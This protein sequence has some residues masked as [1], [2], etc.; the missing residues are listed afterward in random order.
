MAFNPDQYEQL[1]F[2]FLGRHAERPDVP[3]LYESRDLT[4]HAL[5]VGM[6]GSGKT[7][8]CVTLLEEALIDRVPAIVI[9]PKGDIGNL[10]LTFPDLRA[11]DFAPWLDDP[12]EGEK[13]ATRWRDGLASWGQSPDRIQRLRDAGNVTIYTP[14]STAGRPVSILGSLTAPTAAVRDDSEALAQRVSGSVSSLLT[15]LGTSSPDPLQDPEHVFLSNLLHHHWSRGESLD[16]AGLIRGIQNPPFDRIGVMGV[17]DV[18]DAKKRAGLAM[19]ANNLLG[20][21]SFAPWLDGDP[22]DVGEFL[23][24][25]DKPRIA[26]FS[27]AHLDEQQRMF[28]VSLLASRMLDW[29]RSQSGTS[30]LR[31]LFYMDEVMG[32]LP[33]VAN[34]PSKEP[35]LAMLKQ[36]RAAGLGLVLATQNPVDMDYKAL[37]NI[38]TWFLGRLQ[39]EQDVERVVEGLLGADDGLNRSEIERML[40]GLQSR[41][42]LMRNVHEDEP[43][44]IESR[45]ALSFLRGPLSAADI[46]KLT[47]QVKPSDPETRQ[48]EPVVDAVAP[49]VGPTERSG[50]HLPIRVPS[51]ADEELLWRP[52]AYAEGHADI[53]G[54]QIPFN[55]IRGLQGGI[56]FDWEGATAV[57]LD[58]NEFLDSS[59]AGTHLDVDLKAEDKATWTRWHK[60]AVSHV[61]ATVGR[62]ELACP[63]L[64]LKMNDG[65]SESAFRHRVDVAIREKRDAAVDKLRTRFERKV[66]RLEGQLAR[67]REALATQEDQ[68][69]DAG[70]NAAVN[71]GEVLLGM[72]GGRKRRVSSSRAT[73][74]VREKRDVA[75]AEE[76]VES[77]VADLYDLQSEMEAALIDEREKFATEDYPVTQ[78]RQRPRASDVHVGFC[79]LVWVPYWQQADG[80]R[81]RAV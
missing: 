52:M 69:R 42:F 13:I 20:A 61:T 29:C 21:P 65:E 2:F 48:T 41:R 59:K 8:L 74:V 14:G 80:S 45:W 67:A 15:L 77:L 49:V 32:F 56:D 6:T 62:V 57:D 78:K 51:S 19:K 9:D 81:R 25:G 43:S 33:P 40:A 24:D 64:R 11:E 46:R 44:I 28:F 68:M 53:D 5:A 73:R 72:F 55:F 17:D 54:V 10:C 71:V 4:T 7:G 12:N 35:I 39:T 63:K 23:W 50:A 22:L 1:G 70:L 76:K 79:G 31:A 16:L 34:P 58:R 37:S 30:A 47:Q 66:D 3:F 27:L 18:F 26:V 38:G 60:A 75:R 36:A